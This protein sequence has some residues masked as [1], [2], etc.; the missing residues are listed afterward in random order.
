MDAVENGYKI[1]PP[2]DI[3]PAQ[4]K[5]VIDYMSHAFKK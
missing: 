2:I 1:M 5:E 3:T 4:A